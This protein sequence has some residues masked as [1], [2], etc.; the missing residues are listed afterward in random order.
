MGL[1]LYFYRTKTEEIGYFRKVNF[2]V[3]FFE[4]LD[5]EIDNCVPITITK[6]DVEELL[7]RCEEVLNN[8]E[9]AEELLPTTD[10]FFFGNTSYGE[11]YFLDV[12]YVKDYVE[13]ELLPQFEDL[14]SD[15]K[16]EFKIDY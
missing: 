10:G 9:K 14:Y 16:I 5:Y 12:K 2:L 11:D 15:E 3:Y 6:E 7:G 13:N 8:H 1:D 4:S